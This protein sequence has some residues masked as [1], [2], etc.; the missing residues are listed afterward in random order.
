ML[1]LLNIILKYFLICL[2]VRIHYRKSNL[3]T[4][5]AQS[6]KFESPVF[7]MN[8]FHDILLVYTADCQVSF[9]QLLLDEETTRERSSIYLAIYHVI[10][11][12]IYERFPECPQQLFI[13]F[14]I[15][16]FPLGVH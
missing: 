1:V 7:L 5:T 4:H 6:I 9:Y 16:F 14:L 13:V 12:S 10:R 11:I 15:R 8:M 2:Q 3:D